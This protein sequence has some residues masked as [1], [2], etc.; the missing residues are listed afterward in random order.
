[1]AKSLVIVESPAKAG[2]INKILGRDYQVEASLGHIRDLPKSKMGV[3]LKNGFNPEYVIP[4]KSK[5]NGHPVKK[6]SKRQRNHLSGYRSGPRRR[7]HQL[8]SGDAFGRR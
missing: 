6:E 8:A 2:T 7:S 5:K 3:D 4:P 1:L